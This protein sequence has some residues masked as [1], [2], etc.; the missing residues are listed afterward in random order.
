M[1]T[2][3]T[4]PSPVPGDESQPLVPVPQTP[5]KIDLTLQMLLRTMKLPRLNALNLKPPTAQIGA[6][7][8]GN[9]ARLEEILE[10]NF[11][12]LRP[13]E[14]PTSLKPDEKQ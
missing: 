4:S 7:E 14:T 6:V 2:S 13:L 3:P 9:K 8:A 12:L 5:V 10:V 1:S 11:P